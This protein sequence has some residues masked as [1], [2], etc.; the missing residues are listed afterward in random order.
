M[1]S[2]YKYLAGHHENCVICTKKD[3][4]KSIFTINAWFD[5]MKELYYVNVTDDR[6]SGFSSLYLIM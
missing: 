1:K 5:V 2:I 4:Y 3:L 6:S